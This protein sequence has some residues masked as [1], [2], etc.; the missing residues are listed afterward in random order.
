MKIA[1]VCQNYNWESFSIVRSIYE[2]LPLY[3]CEV[4]IHHD[5]ESIDWNPDQ[6]WVASSLIPLKRYDIFTVVF[7]LSDPNMYHRNRVEFGDLYCT[8]DL[9]ISKKY[10]HYHFAHCGD[11]RYFKALSLEKKADCI[12]IGTGLHNWIPERYEMV[13]RLRAGGLR[14]VVYGPNWPKHPD[15][16][17]YIKGDR[18]VRAYNIGSLMVDLTNR[19]TSLSNRIIQASMCGTPVLTANREDV[20]DLFSFDKEVFLYNGIDDLVTKAQE[21]L[22][23]RTRLHQVGLAARDR[24]LEEHD[25]SNRVGALLE[26]IK[27][28]KGI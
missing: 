5:M 19:R 12:F 6:I 15:N 4:R 24:S 14:V 22:V 2:T 23:N 13:D 16:L 7:G 11:K 18:L 28:L 26:H 20:K 17:G 21:A 8:A 27:K 1:Y 3:G 9:R 10:G 25:I